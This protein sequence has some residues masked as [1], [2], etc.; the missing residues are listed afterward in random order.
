VQLLSLRLVG[1]PPFED[2]TIPLADE[3]G[4]PRPMTVL[5]GG[6]GVGKT[7]ALAALSSTRPGYAVALQPA[8]N[9]APFAVTEWSLGKDD[10]ERPHPLRV[11]S[12]TARTEDDEQQEL[13]RR[14]EQA[15]F[16]RVAR[17]GGFVFVSIPS[18]R[19]FSRQPI[20]L[21]APARTIARYDV[22]ALSTS[23][24]TSR[25][26]LAR[27]TKQ[28]L[29]YAAI[30]SALTRD[31]PA[32]PFAR[33]GEA[34]ARVVDLLVS[35]AGLSYV[36]ID[37][38]SFEPLFKSEDGQLLTFDG[39]PTRA[40]H[41]AAFGALPVRALWAAYPAGD[42]SDAEG[43]V[44]IDEVELQQDVAVQGAVLGCLRAALPRVQWIVTTS[45]AVVAASAE[46]SEVLALRRLPR[47][48]EVRLF[49]GAEAR[50]H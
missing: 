35:L 14:R 2:V 42:P 34:M 47:L 18:T 19:W 43:V 40:R 13:V 17:D 30:A 5:F 1:L 49:S 28:A 37:P 41:L 44:C 15:H 26:D 20:V 29:A 6:G 3:G 21:S 9:G 7:T 22:R 48:Q 45:S 31:K 23:E 32:Q 33:L 4:S 25:T 39:L 10:P 8:G 27:E 38:G 46:G 11:A 24:D 50:V 16:D 12:P 36:G